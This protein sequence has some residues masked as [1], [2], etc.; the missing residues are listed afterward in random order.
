MNR[1]PLASFA[2]DVYSQFGEDG[3]LSEVLDRLDSVTDLD[4]WCVEVGAWDGVYFSN[5]CNL[6]RERGYRAVMIECDPARARMIVQHHPGD[7]VI[8]IAARVGTS[9]ADSLDAILARTPVPPDFDVCSI[10]VDGIDYW[11]LASLRRSRPK[12]VVIEYNPTVPN[13][14]DYVQA[15]DPRVQRGAS[16]AALCRLAAELGYVLVAV[17][18]C[19]LVLVRADLAG[20]VVD[21]STA[22]GDLRSPDEGVVHAFAGY[23]GTV[24]LDRALEIPW[25]ERQFWGADLQVVPALLRGYRPN[26]RGPR[27][28]AWRVWS[29]FRG[30]VHA[31]GARVARTAPLAGPGTVLARAESGAMPGRP[32]GQPT[33]TA[34]L[35]E[36]LGALH[37][38][39]PGVPLV[40][41][42]PDADGGYLVPDDLD[43]IEACFSPGVGL[44][45]GFEQD[46]ADRG[47]AVFLADG[48]VDDPTG[49]DPRLRFVRTNVGAT[50]G[51][52]VVSLRRWIADSLPGVSG[53]LLLQIDVEGA[54]YATLLA[55]PP[56]V[57]A[58]FR[59]VVVELHHLELLGS[60]GFF[61]VVRATL[62][63]LWPTHVCVHSHPNNADRLVSVGGVL[64]PA[65]LE[66][67]LLRRDRI[68]T[69]DE[70]F[71]TEFPHPLDRDNAEA[72][73]LVLPP[74]LRRTVGA[75]AT[76]S[77]T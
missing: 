66:V 55:A 53:D 36:F 25:L 29:A 10:D 69:D 58:R 7:A 37:P 9:G 21:G 32:V 27:E 14:V 12:V 17:T 57:L 33:S 18:V 35:L 30:R 65:T 31:L 64:V 59:I 43:G 67:T 60:A 50:D 47:M 3:I 39:D 26:R 73:S 38:R 41:L 28:V 16:A 23:D 62:D 48:T 75:P 6:V 71:A 4:R 46:C 68:R 15:S 13:A 51:D 72:P 34:A 20:A 2:A 56:E 45:T 76:G 70:Q 1:P 74:A 61:D 11:I 49:G 22:L 63:R 77:P 5:T 40:R 19:N 8:P 54:E 52:G 24:L 44:V 42:G